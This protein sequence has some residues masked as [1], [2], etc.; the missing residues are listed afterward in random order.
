MGHGIGHVYIYMYSLSSEDRQRE[1]QKGILRKTERER[2]YDP[3][4]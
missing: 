2:I 1:R 3:R 4:K